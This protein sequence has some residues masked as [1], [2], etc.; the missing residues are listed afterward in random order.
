MTEEDLKYRK[1][2]DRL[3]KDLCEQNNIK[4]LIFPYY[5]DPYLRHPKNIQEFIINEFVRLTGIK[6]RKYNIPL[7]DHKTKEFGQYRLDNYLS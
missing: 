3:T 4:L 7:F 1:L 6:I 5:I 2:L